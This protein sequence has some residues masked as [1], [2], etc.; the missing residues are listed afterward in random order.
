MYQTSG[1]QNISQ[2]IFTVTISTYSHSTHLFEHLQVHGKVEMKSNS[3]YPQ[4]AYN[5]GI[6]RCIVALDHRFLVS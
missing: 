6:I 5:E 1:I 2:I 3:S 4:D